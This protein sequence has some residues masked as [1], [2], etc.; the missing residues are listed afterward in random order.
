MTLEHIASE[1]DD[2]HPATSRD[3]HS[4]DHLDMALRDTLGSYGPP[5]I[6]SATI[7]HVI[8]KKKLDQ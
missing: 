6:S 4:A 2:R 7:G 1:L 8:L 3:V 5:G